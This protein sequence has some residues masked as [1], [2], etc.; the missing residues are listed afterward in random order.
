MLWE[1]DTDYPGLMWAVK[2]QLSQLNVATDEMSKT[3][4]SLESAWK[5]APIDF[6]DFEARI[7]NKEKQINQ[8]KKKADLAI[9][10]YEDELRVTALEALRLH[11]NQIKLYHDRALYA[12]ARLYDSL[13]ER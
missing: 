5:T 3:M 1:V 10:S 8:L 13:M 12:K 7:K 6:S 11:R 4:S 2:K 9:T